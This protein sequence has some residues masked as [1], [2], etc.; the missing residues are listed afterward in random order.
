MLHNNMCNFTI[1]LMSRDTSV[2]E[3]KDF[4]IFKVKDPKLNQ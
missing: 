1:K 3:L 4:K 2:H